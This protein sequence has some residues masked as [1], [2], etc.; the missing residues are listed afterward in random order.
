MGLLINLF[1]TLSNATNRY[2]QK[3]SAWVFYLGSAC[4]LRAANH[5]Y[6]PPPGHYTPDWV[7]ANLDLSGLPTGLLREHGTPFTRLSAFNGDPDSTTISTPL[8]C[9][10]VHATL[11]SATVNANAQ[12]DTAALPPESGSDTFILLYA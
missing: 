2:F 3:L 6:V 10:L 8:R 12:V 7:F 5:R 1:K 11:L 4:A 9:R